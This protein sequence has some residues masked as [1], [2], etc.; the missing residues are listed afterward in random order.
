M[1]SV[2]LNRREM[3]RNCGMGFGVLGLTGLLSDEHALGSETDEMTASLVAKPSHFPGQAKHV[4]HLFMNGGASQVDTFDPKP[5]KLR[6]YRY[7]IFAP[8][9][10]PD[11]Q[12]VHRFVL[13]SMANRESKSVSYFLELPAMLMIWQSYVR[14]MP[15]RQIM[16]LR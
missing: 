14:C 6:V 3:L 16:S 5:E 11:M 4:V 15:T 1:T 9:A 8:S 10:R 12:W 2:A 13:T 7:K